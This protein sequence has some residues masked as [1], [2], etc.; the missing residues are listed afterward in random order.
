MIS[1]E[2]KDNRVKSLVYLRSNP[3]NLVKIQLMPSDGK[4]GRCTIGMVCEAM[5]RSLSGYYDDTDAYRHAEDAVA[6]ESQIMWEINDGNDEYTWEDIADEL[7]G[8]WA[9]NPDE[10]VSVPDYFEQD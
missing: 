4:M 8:I 7:A 1:Q 10:Y 3:D 5:G 9:E 6:T 2:Q